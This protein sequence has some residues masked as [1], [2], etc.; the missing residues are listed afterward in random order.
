MNGRPPLIPMLYRG[1][2]RRGTTLCTWRRLPAWTSPRLLSNPHLLGSLSIKYRGS[3]ELCNATRQIAIGRLAINV[4]PVWKN[5]RHLSR[6]SRNQKGDA[7]PRLCGQLWMIRRFTSAR[8]FPQS[9]GAK[10]KNHSGSGHYGICRVALRH[11]NRNGFFA[12]SVKSSGDKRLRVFYP[13]TEMQAEWRVKARSFTIDKLNR[14]GRASTDDEW[15]GTLCDR[16][17]W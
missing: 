4:L 15:A 7:A 3:Y 12:E 17:G 2:F 1:L 5:S 14:Q 16:D 6:T 9:A 8:L 10:Q 13:P 11:F